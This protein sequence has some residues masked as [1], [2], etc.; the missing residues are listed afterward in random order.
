MPAPPPALI[1]LSKT[2]PFMLHWYIWQVRYRDDLSIRHKMGFGYRAGVFYPRGARHGQHHD[3]WPPFFDSM[4]ALGLSYLS[5]EALFC[6][7]KYA[8]CRVFIDT[9]GGTYIFP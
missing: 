1:E 3:D 5:I 9:S 7:Q 2:F 4:A 8:S 6:H